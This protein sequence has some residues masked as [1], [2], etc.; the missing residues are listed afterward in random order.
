VI[1]LLLFN[2]AKKSRARIFKKKKN[3]RIDFLRKRYVEKINSDDLK[4]FLHSE[5]GEEYDG[6][7][8]ESGEELFNAFLAADPSDN[9]RYLLWMLERFL[10]T[11][12][13]E[14]EN[15]AK[16]TYRRRLGKDKE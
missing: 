7:K 14:D 4:H 12:L 11:S 2:M 16:K 6:E 9:K 8:I 5:I 3:G 10:D 15:P 13:D 1:I